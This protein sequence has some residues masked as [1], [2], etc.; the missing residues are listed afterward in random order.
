M[1]KCFLLCG[2][3][4]VLAGC[5]SLQ[6]AP[7][8]PSGRTAF[9][10]TMAGVTN[11]TTLLPEAARVEIGFS[12]DGGALALILG[13]IREARSSIRVAAYTFTSKPIS[14]ALLD[15]H[16]RG[17]DVRV[18]ADAKSNKGK[19]SAAQF[20]AN[21]GL[22]VRLNGKYAIHHHKFMVIDDSTVETGSFNYSAAAAD[23]NA[24]NVLLLRN[25]PALARSY[26]AEWQRLWSEAEGLAAKY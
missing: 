18:V 16:R 14:T 24:E 15:A 21:H 13:A 22:H 10:P 12:P 11:T 7:N 1:K 3:L 6:R 26:A 9:L 25:V 20:L 17:V 5:Q 4:F 8:D 23:K 19:Y 2:L